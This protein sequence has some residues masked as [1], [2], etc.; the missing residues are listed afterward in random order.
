MWPATADE[1]GHYRFAV[2]AAKNKSQVFMYLK[3]QCNS[4]M[5][6]KP[7]GTAVTVDSLVCTSASEIRLRQ[8]TLK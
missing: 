1:D 5:Q 7:T 6:P 2:R 3:L 8:Q 4:S